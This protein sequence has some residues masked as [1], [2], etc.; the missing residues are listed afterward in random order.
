MQRTKRKKYNFRT[1]QYK[2]CCKHIQFISIEFL[3]EE[4]WLVVLDE[5]E[6]DF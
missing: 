5:N 1:L 4:M 6:K 2:V 3:M